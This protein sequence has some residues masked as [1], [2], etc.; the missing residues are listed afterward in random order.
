MKLHMIVTSCL[1]C[2]LAVGQTPQTK[3]PATYRVE[4]DARGVWWFVAPDGEHFVSL[5]IDNISPAPFNP[6]PNTQYYDAVSRQFNGNKGAWGSWVRRLLQ[7]HGFNT[8]G[9]WSN[10]AAPAGD[11]IHRTIVLYAFGFAADRCLSGLR[12]GFEEFV[13]AN[14]HTTLEQYSDR[15]ALLGVFL[16]NEM[17]WAGR[18]PYD[19]S[20]QY[21]LLEVALDLPSADPARTAAI[22]FLKG[23][24]ADVAKFAAAWDVEL[25]DWSTLDAATLQTG[26]TRVAREDRQAFTKLA[27]QR[28]FTTA[29]RVVRNEMP[30]V[31]L[32]GVRY[33]GDAPD[34]VISEDAKISDVISLNDYSG[35]AEASFAKYARFWLQSRKPLMITEFAWRSRENTSGNPNTRGAGAVVATQAERAQAYERFVRGLAEVPI[36]IG[37]HWF[38]FAD[39]SPQGRFDGEDSNYGVVD[40]QNRPYETL[41]HAMERTNGAVPVLHAKTTR[42]MP[43][44]ITRGGQMTF[45][46]LQRADR[47]ATLDLL[48]DWRQPPEIWG[49]A[50]A[51]LTWKLDGSALQLDY[52]A[53]NEYGTGINLNGVKSVT[54]P[55]ATIAS[56]FAG[57]S[58]LV[59]EY[60]APRGVQLNLV[61]SEAG[62]AAP[63]QP[64]YDAKAGDDGEAFISPPF[65]GKGQKATK[66]IEFGDWMR[67]VYY[68]N[69]RGK[70]NIDMQAIRCIG[71]Q[72][73]GKP[74]KGTVRIEA[75]RLER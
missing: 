69:Q 49:A 36:I 57:F 61:L 14:I 16:D 9:A 50:D 39:Q 17:Q 12:P 30:G 1:L 21:S 4:A 28:L 6:R 60:M 33:A 13:R 2:G 44:E 68:G 75:M 58:A 34:G 35:D 65:F 19:P 22:E 26:A 56:D 59:I 10:A 64:S 67:Q 52:E 48:S 37:A 66:R 7:E 63:G 15:K 70:N 24:Y 51:K 72:V 46:K 31:L 45:T 43:T 32:L 38:E 11:G 8:L 71:I 54:P 27:A 3:A 41:L 18:G 74:A 25:T 5:G 53:G 40:I 62:A 55:G 42:T 29:A 20:G 73:Q 47:P 23:R